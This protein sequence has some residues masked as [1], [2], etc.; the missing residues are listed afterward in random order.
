MKLDKIDKRILEK[1]VELAECQAAVIAK[2]LAG[3]RSESVIRARINS[4]DLLGA[5]IQDRTKERGKVFVTITPYGLELLRRDC[6]SNE[7]VG[8]S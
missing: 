1:V 7:E 4:L 5:V 2:D 6:R 8:S 3:L